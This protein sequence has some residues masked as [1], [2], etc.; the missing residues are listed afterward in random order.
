MLE[1]LPAMICLLTLDYKVAFANRSFIERFGESQG[2]HCYEYC[3]GRTEPCDFCESF[4]VLKTGNPHH[5]EVNAPDGSVIESHDYPFTDV[6]GTPMILEM[7]V[8]ITQRKRIEEELK[9]ANRAYQIMAKCKEAMIHAEDETA[10]MDKICRIIVDVGGYPLAWIGYIEDD[11]ARTVRPVAWAGVNSGYVENLR[12]YLNDPVRGNGPTGECLKTGKP[13]SIGDVRSDPRMAP[14]REAA[15]TRGFISTLN[16]PLVYEKHVIGNITTYSPE[17]NAFNEK[18]LELMF[19]LAGNLAYG[20]TTLRD[21]SKRLLAEDGLRRSH[22][23][24]DSRV[25]ERTKELM[26]SEAN[27]ARAQQMSRIGSWTWDIMTDKVEWSDQSYRNYGLTPGEVTPTYDLFLSFIVPEDR[28]RVDNEVRNAIEAGS[29]YNVIYGII[30]N[31]GVRRVLLS[32]NEVI[33]DSSGKVVNMYGTNQDITERKH[34]EDELRE[35]Q[36]KIA[37]LAEEL[38]AQME[39]LRTNNEELET[40]IIERKRA[41]EEIKRSEVDQKNLN[42]QLKESNEQL[43][44]ILKVTESAMSTLEI[45]KLLGLLLDHIVKAMKCNASVILLKEG[46]LVQVRASTGIRYDILPGFSESVGQGFAGTIVQSGNPQYIEGAKTDSQIDYPP[47]K[48]A[49]I[50]SV[51]GVPVR[52]RSE[53]IGVIHVDWVNIHPYNRQEQ[54]FLQIIAD[55]CGIAIENAKLYQ[56]CMSQN[57]KL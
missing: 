42:L 20:I 37:V 24:L 16:I 32:E 33:T 5:W 27:L 53:V 3:F 56:I 28:E 10:L 34:A 8:D 49:G 11:D 45:E 47:F 7:D 19:E 22:D 57:E 26:E 14:W 2:R 44:A 55:H 18:E 30:R 13:V 54:D 29:K 21:R 31:D 15:L 52:G 6:D 36:K 38:E 40:Q 35:K 43:K 9:K 12:I 39:E 17:A 48:E 25:K 23:E 4:N 46:N 41:E 1:T 51:L 50:S